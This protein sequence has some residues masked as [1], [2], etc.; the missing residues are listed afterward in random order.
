[1]YALV[2]KM[3]TVIAMSPM[4]SYMSIAMRASPIQSCPPARLVLKIAFGS[5]LPGR[6]RF[7]G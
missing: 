1:M 6:L 4:R 7:A 5:S 2:A 3:P